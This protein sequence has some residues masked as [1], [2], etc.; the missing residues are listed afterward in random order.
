MNAISP[1]VPGFEIGV[2]IGGKTPTDVV[3][4]SAQW[5]HAAD[6]GANDPL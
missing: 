6:E 1:T 2:D 5:L 3:C 4:P